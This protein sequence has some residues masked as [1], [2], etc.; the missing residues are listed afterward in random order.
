MAWRSVGMAWPGM[1]LHS[2]QLHCAPL[3]LSPSHFF[4]SLQHHFHPCNPAPA[5]SVLSPL[6]LEISRHAP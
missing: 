6:H 1:S 4:I 3:M 2:K 5:P